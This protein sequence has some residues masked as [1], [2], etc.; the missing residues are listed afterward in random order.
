MTAEE[1]ALWLAG[2]RE[3]LDRGHVPAIAGPPS[4]HPQVWGAGERLPE[5]LAWIG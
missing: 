4:G 2:H 1:L 5:C 3:A